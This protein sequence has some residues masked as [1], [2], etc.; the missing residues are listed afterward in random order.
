[1]KRF[2]QPKMADG[3]ARGKTK[4]R[5]LITTKQDGKLDLIDKDDAVNGGNLWVYLPPPCAA[6]LFF[7]PFCWQVC[8]VDV[9]ST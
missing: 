4:S 1:M 7:L 5:A 2:R 8:V 3:K 9:M 6:L